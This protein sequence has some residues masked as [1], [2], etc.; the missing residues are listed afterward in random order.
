M[1]TIVTNSP[2]PPRM[3]LKAAIAALEES[4]QFAK[5]GEHG[6]RAH[7]L[8]R[9]AD[10]ANMGQL[11]ERLTEQR[12]EVDL[13]LAVLGAADRAIGRRHR[14]ASV[15]SA[16]SVAER[17]DHSPVEAFRQNVELHGVRDSR[18]ARIRQDLRHD[19]H[20]AAHLL[21]MAAEV[22]GP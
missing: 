7:Q 18:Q 10:E 1:T 12:D 19:R 13:A 15:M 8:Q 11:V 3:A 2:A 6:G 14:L 16:A 22:L 20:D 17:L 9:H 5:A 21:D 4:L